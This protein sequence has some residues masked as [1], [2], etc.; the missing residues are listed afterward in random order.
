MGEKGNNYIWRSKTNKSFTGQCHVET[1][2]TWLSFK[3]NS[4]LGRMERS[5]D[6]PGNP[7]FIEHDGKVVALRGAVT[8]GTPDTGET[9]T[10][11]FTPQDE[12][13]TDWHWTLTHD[14]KTYTEQ[15]RGIFLRGER[16][17]ARRSRVKKAAK[18]ATTKRRVTPTK[19]AA[20]RKKIAKAKKAKRAVKRKPR[21]RGR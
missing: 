21:G 13:L 18:K 1:G 11:T 8:I 3:F 16:K 4:D 10:V 14:G 15:G 2:N 12:G 6:S 19:K 17:P 9:G 5:Q 7:M 20:P